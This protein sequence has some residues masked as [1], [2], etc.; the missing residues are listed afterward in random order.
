MRVVMR[1]FAAAAVLA[2]GVGA[3]AQDRKDKDTKPFSD[4]EFVVKAASDGMHE[5]ELGNLAKTNAAGSDVRKFGERMVTDHSKANKELMDIAK[6]ANLGVPTKMLD[7]HAKHVEH[8]GK[9][10]GADFDKAYVKHMVEDHKEA[11][12]LFTRASKEAKD[13]KLKAFAEKTL[14]V[15]K[16]HL[17]MAQK[18]D[19][20]SGK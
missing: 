4:A 12:D 1:V 14:P 7:E 20:G 5:V 6:G 17:E 9:L 16:E 19:K 3:T 18:L 10:K 13:A 11:V 8:M 2:L 15:I